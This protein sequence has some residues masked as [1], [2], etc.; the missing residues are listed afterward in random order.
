MFSKYWNGISFDFHLS[1]QLSEFNMILK[2]KMTG[3]FSYCNTS[4]TV[5]FNG[6]VWYKY[7]YNNTMMAKVS[8]S[9]MIM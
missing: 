4:L 3:S 6:N 2:V 5:V 9:V 7:V 1:Q 8:I